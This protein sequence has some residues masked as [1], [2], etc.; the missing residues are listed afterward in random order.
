MLRE[1]GEE[2]SGRFKQIEAVGLPG[3]RERLPRVWLRRK[4]CT[5]GGLFAF[6]VLLPPLP[7]EMSALGQV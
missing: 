2:M 7:G 5:A 6:V 1:G 3:L 4:R